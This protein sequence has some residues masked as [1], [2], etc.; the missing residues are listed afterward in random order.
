MQVP[1]AAMVVR[2][3][4]RHGLELPIFRGIDALLSGRITLADGMPL[5]MD[6]PLHDED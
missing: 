6:R 1:T 2:L 4:D 3:A 5:I